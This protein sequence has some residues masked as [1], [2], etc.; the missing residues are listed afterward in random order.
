MTYT[1]AAIRPAQAD[2]E[3]VIRHGM[4]KGY[5]I[6]SLIAPPAY[7]IWVLLG[8]GKLSVNRLLRATW[9]G[10]AVCANFSNPSHD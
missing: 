9:I 6:F 5:Q 3:Y 1:M 8:K 7:A 2:S 10:G 4:T